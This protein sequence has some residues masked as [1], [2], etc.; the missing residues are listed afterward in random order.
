ML[1]IMNLF[2]SFMFLRDSF[3][4]KVDKVIIVSVNQINVKCLSSLYQNLCDSIELIN[5]TFTFHLIIII[6]NAL[7]IELFASYGIFWE[8]KVQSKLM[9]FVLLQN[10]AWLS[11][12]YVLQ[13]LSAHAGSSLTTNGKETLSIINRILNDYDRSDDLTTSLQNF[14][15]RTGSRNMLIENIFFVIDWKLLVQVTLTL[16]SVFET[17]FRSICNDYFFPSSDNI[18]HRNVPCHHNAI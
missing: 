9:L 16:I 15:S 5:S 7:I 8:F 4:H 1:L 14:I 6:V 12:Q 13:I 11:M 2:I 18:D 17:M 3:I 10:T